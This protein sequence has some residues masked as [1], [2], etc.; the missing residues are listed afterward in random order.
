MGAV[1][2][3]KGK[4]IKVIFDD[5]ED[6]RGEYGSSVEGGSSSEADDEYYIR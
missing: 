1:K 5:E 3:Y 6:A 4:D 2:P